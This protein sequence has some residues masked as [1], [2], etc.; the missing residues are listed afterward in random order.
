M[1]VDYEGYGMSEG[2]PSESG[3]Y[4]S[5]DAAYEYALTRKEVD[6]HRI[7]AV[8]WS[9]GGAV[10]IDLASRKP[11]M[12]LAT[13]SAFTSIFDMSK[14]I[15]PDVP[16]AMALNSRFDNLAK[17]RSI[18]CPIFLAQGTKDPLVPPQMLDRLRAAANAKVTTVRVEGA[19][20][21][22]VFQYDDSLYDRFKTFVDQLQSTPDSTSPG[23]GR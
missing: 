10:A 17:I 23:R 18:T 12:G 1:M 15:A 21:N 20:H 5:A 16:A 11:M 22:D 13:F 8:G 19:G 9:L 14:V 3:C 6:P 4:A 2:T 7:I